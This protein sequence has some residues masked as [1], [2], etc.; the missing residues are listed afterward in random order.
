MSLG[1]KANDM[2]TTGSAS[3]EHAW[4][5]ILGVLN[6]PPPRLTENL[7]LADI[8]GWDSMAMV[9]LV[10]A[11]EEKFGRQLSDAEIENIETVADVEKLVTARQ[12]L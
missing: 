2:S 10:V 5:L 6:G 4:N 8:P 12:P 7:E 9:R 1:S 11:L 3:S